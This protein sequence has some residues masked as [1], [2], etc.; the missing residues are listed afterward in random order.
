MIKLIDLIK[1]NIDPKKQYKDLLPKLET[2]NKANIEKDWKDAGDNV[3]KQL[4]VINKIK[5]F[6]KQVIKEEQS[7]L[8]FGGN[9]LQSIFDK[10]LKLNPSSGKMPTKSKNFPNDKILKYTYGTGELIFVIDSNNNPIAAIYDDDRA[11]DFLKHMESKGFGPNI[12]GTLKSLSKSSSLS[13][14]STI[15]NF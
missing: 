6:L 3:I 13:G 11:N 1:E 10:F 4:K 8:D 2:G 9:E 5:D 15:V 7:K 12:F 14:Y